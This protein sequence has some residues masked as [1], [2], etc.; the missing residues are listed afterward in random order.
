MLQFSQ[1][2]PESKNFRWSWGANAGCFVCAN[3]NRASGIGDGF[4]HWQREQTQLADM[5]GIRAAPDN[6][7]TLAKLCELLG[8]L[9]G[10][11]ESQNLGPP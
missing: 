7:E 6:R 5:T 3:R 1:R 11:V 2:W 10:Q 8:L 4:G 9:G